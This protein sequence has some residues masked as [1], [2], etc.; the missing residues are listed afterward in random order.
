MSHTVGRSAVLRPAVSK[1][2]SRS[3]R[4]SLLLRLSQAVCRSVSRKSEFAR[5]PTA[6]NDS[7][8]FDDD[9][10]DDDGVSSGPREHIADIEPHRESSVLHNKPRRWPHNFRNTFF[11]TANRLTSRTRPFGEGSFTFRGQS[12]SDAAFERFEQSLLA[13]PRSS[14][15]NESL[16]RSADNRKVDPNPMDWRGDEAH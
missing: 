6:Y 3:F 9:G 14:V 10:D 5:T 15:P 7:A 4:R 2:L 13:P 16:V 8:T 1:S 12:D 11:R